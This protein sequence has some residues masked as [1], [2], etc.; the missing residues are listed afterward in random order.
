MDSP[1]FDPVSA[2]GQVASGANVIA[3]TTGR[4]SCYGCVPA[5]SLK[6]ATNTPMFE[7]MEDDMDINCGRIIDGD[8]TIQQMGDIIFDRII[9]LASGEASK[10]EALGVG[11]DEFQ[12]WNIGIIS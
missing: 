8:A 9:R 7:R 4:G 10:S 2:T 5:P 3:F 12:P 1:G 6:L 11:E